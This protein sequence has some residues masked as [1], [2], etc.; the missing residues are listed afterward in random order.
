MPNQEPGRAPK[1]KSSSS[2]R[3]SSTRNTSS[4]NQS[5]QRKQ[6]NRTTQNN[7]K[8]QPSNRAPKNSKKKNTGLAA[9]LYSDSRILFILGAIIIVGIIIIFMLT[10]KGGDD[11]KVADAPSQAISSSIIENTST[12]PSVASESLPSQENIATATSEVSGE[13]QSLSSL[14]NSE[15][16]SKELSSEI[17]SVASKKEEAV[18]SVNQVVATKT[19]SKDSS[20]TNEVFELAPG[21]VF[22]FN[23]A[24]LQQKVAVSEEEKTLEATELARQYEIDQIPMI[25]TA[26]TDGNQTEPSFQSRIQAAKEYNDETVG[27][28]RIKGT[29]INFAVV[30]SKK[31]NNY[32]ESL[33]YDKKYSH[34]VWGSGTRKYGDYGVIWAA[35]NSNL[36]SREDLSDNTV[37]FGHNWENISATPRMSSSQDIMMEHIVGYTYTEYAQENPYINF[38]IDGEDM[39]WVIVAGFYTEDYWSEGSKILDFDYVDTEF[40]DAQK[41]L[42]ISEIQSRSQFSTD[43][44]MTVDDKFLTISTCTRAKG[45]RSDQRFAVVARLVREDEELPELTYTDNPNIKAPV[46]S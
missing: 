17:E 26:N 22:S 32:Y 34:H 2:T 21:Q 28:I 4:R 5:T 6:N 13:V 27:W 38:S 19:K 10:R 16:I 30:Q 29:G 24:T 1:K 41:E 15:M 45:S 7:R 31:N 40:T 3:N 25:L 39:T 42:F 43:D 23:G 44:V 46:F 35:F 14:E 20:D 9:I 36:T 33:G 11:L 37:I 18:S 12:L 8:T